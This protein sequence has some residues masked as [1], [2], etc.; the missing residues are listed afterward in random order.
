MTEATTKRGGAKNKLISC[1]TRPR[2]QS[3]LWRAICSKSVFDFPIILRKSNNFNMAAALVKRSILTTRL[4]SRGFVCQTKKVNSRSYILFSLLGSL[5]LHQSGQSFHVAL[6]RWNRKNFH[7]LTFVPRTKMS[8]FWLTKNT[9]MHLTWLGL[10]LAYQTF[11]NV[12]TWVHLFGLTNKA[13]WL[14]SLT[15]GARKS[16]SRVSLSSRSPCIGSIIYAQI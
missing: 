4:R 8:P 16:L 11:R 10:S 5:F 3:T 7:R 2:E 14:E 1:F 12:T 9:V 6:E 13:T 15:S